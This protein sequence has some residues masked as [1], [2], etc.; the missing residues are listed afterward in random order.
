VPLEETL[1]AMDDLVGQGKIRYA[2][3]SNFEAWRLCEARCISE[4]DQ[5]APFVCD[6]VLYNLLDRRIEDELIP[7]C[8]Q[9]QI[10]ITVFA[11]TALGLLSGG[12]R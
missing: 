5:L 2:G 11:A 9:Q 3:C 10:A 7:Y 6:Q 12:C 8:Q 1:Q 4:R